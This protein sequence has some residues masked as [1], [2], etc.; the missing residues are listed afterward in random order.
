[1]PYGPAP[2]DLRIGAL[3]S[4]G[5]THVHWTGDFQDWIDPPPDP[6]DLAAR[7]RAHVAQQETSGLAAV[8]DLHDSS[9][10]YADRRATVEAVGIL[11]ADQTLDVFTVPSRS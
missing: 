3:A 4:I 8:L 9:R 6:A 10:L 5:R 7:M 1:L 2:G 11:L